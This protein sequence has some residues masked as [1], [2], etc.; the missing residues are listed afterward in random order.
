MRLSD[1]RAFLSYLFVLFCIG[2]TGVCG[3]AHLPNT[4]PLALGMSPQDAATALGTPIV[5][6]TRA[7]APMSTPP[8]ATQ[9]S[10]VIRSASACSCN[11]AAAPSPAGNTTGACC[12]MRLSKAR[13]PHAPF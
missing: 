7:P 9:A 11:S 5:R 2:W 6:V 13:P 8:T 3:G 4:L 12:R 10:Q 1:S